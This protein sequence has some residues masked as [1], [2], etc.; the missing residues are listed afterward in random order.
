MDDSAG[1]E[2]PVILVSLTLQ[3]LLELGA[4]AA[5]GYWGYSTGRDA[6]RVVLAVGAPAVAAT[7]WGLF[8]SPKAPFHLTGG[9]RLLFEAAFFGSAVV[10]LAAAGKKWPA[11]VFAVIVAANV[12][13]LNARGRG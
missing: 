8:G 9:F 6:M 10:A 13:V 11:V 3:F 2:G 4:L 12:A 1:I 7:A 5:L